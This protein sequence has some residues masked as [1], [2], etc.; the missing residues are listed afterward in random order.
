VRPG[1]RMRSASAW[2]GRSETPFFQ[3]VVRLDRQAGASGQADA[4]LFGKGY[5]NPRELLQKWQISAE[6]AARRCP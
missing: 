6:G 2:T 3:R 4:S 1:R 5:I